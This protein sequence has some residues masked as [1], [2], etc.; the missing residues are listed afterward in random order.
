M[1]QQVILALL[2]MSNA[3]KP[4][5]SFRAGVV[6]LEA[7]AGQVVWTQ[8]TIGEHVVQHLEY[9]KDVLLVASLV[10]EHMQLAEPV[11]DIGGYLRTKPTNSGC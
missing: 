4:F 8:Q 1:L 6:T 2:A 3:T 10:Q 5:V 7:P 11:P 9:P